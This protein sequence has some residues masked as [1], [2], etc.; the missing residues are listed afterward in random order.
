ML[1]LSVPYAQQQRSPRQ[2]RVRVSGEGVLWHMVSH[3]RVSPQ[4]GIARP[5]D[6]FQRREA[7]ALGRV[8][9]KTHFILESIL[10][11]AWKAA[12]LLCAHPFLSNRE[13]LSASKHLIK[14]ATSLFKPFYFVWD[15]YLLLSLSSP[16]C[17]LRFRL[18]L[19]KTRLP[20]ITYWRSRIP[21]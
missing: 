8:L 21:W 17:R 18:W 16:P 10:S 1:P 11:T 15:G 2:L 4:R 14:K 20:L 19:T 5:C 6:L 3:P 7:G 9:S 12:S 13:C